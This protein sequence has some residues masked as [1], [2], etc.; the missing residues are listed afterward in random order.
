LALGGLSGRLD[1]KFL[2]AYWLPAFV[3]VTGAFGIL[4]VLVG[5]EQ[6]DAWISGFDSVEQ[7]LGIVLIILAISMMSFV[8]RALSRPIGKLFAGESLPQAVAEWSTRGQL[9]RKTRAAQALRA[10]R[11][12]PESVASMRRAVWHQQAFPRNDDDVQPTSFGNVFATAAEQPRAAYLIE[13]WL[14]WPR[15][16]PLLPEEF[17]TILG[18]AQAPMMA[19]FN[20]SVVFIPLA[21]GGAVVLILDGGRWAMAIIVLGGGLLLSWLCYHAAVSQAAELGN[22]MQV[23]FDLYRH[24]IL[25]QMGL[26]IPPD[27][28]DERALWR[29]LAAEL[30]GHSEGDRST[31]DATADKVP[32]RNVSAS[33]P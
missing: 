19:L 9:V 30:L 13:G 25:R 2:I 5:P 11:D 16:F 7:T 32:T 15:L 12:R 29:K 20:L 10:N 21:L 3:A 31:G 22:Q 28:E 23:G 4:A 27:L 8:L 14:W 17:Q 33:E 18:G 1:S 24:E 26:E 6:I